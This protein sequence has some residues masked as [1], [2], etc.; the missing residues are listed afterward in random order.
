[1]KVQEDSTGRLDAKISQDAGTF[2]LEGETYSKGD[3]VFLMPG[4]FDELQN[5][6][7]LSGQVAEYASKGRFHKGGA[8]AG[9]R[10]YGIAQLRGLKSCNTKN[11]AAAVRNQA[12]PSRPLH[13]GHSLIV[14]SWKRKTSI[15]L[16]I[17]NWRIK[18]F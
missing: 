7:G 14:I 17:I 10:P 4:V 1:M 13:I 15:H 5:A 11:K 12:L 8:N 3:F 6:G 2:A 18:G 9:L 16:T